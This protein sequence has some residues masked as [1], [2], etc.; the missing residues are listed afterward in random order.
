MT[1]RILRPDEVKLWRKVAKTVKPKIKVSRPKQSEN[2]EDFGQMLSGHIR[3]E[4]LPKNHAKSKAKATETQ[5]Q[6]MDE[7]PELVP[8]SPV[9]NRETE[10]RIR[11]G[12]VAVD[13]HLDLHGYTQVNARAA[14][15][16]FLVHHRA[17]GARAVLVITGKGKMGE[18]VIR[19]RLREWLSD[20]DVRVHV[21][22]YAQSHQK[23]G[24]AGAFYLFLRRSTR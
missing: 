16:R 8:N 6:M 4:I 2:E 10:R 1:K 22:S 24:G 17:Q 9:L 12:K 20:A 14:L 23:H 21:S 3:Q 11:R 15:L 18:G 7:S 5:R 13:A 19:S